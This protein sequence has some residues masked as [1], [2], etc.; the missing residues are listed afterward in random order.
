M[1]RTRVGEGRE[2][3]IQDVE[4]EISRVLIRT[5]YYIINSPG[6][7]GRVKRIERCPPSGNKLKK[8]GHAVRQLSGEHRGHRD[9]SYCN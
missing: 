7:L 1:F 3:P 4:K 9:D 6:D 8:K 2:D 5:L